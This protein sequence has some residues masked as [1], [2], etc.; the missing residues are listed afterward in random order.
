[1][2]YKR[3]TKNQWQQFFKVLN[4]GEKV[5]FLIFSVFFFVSFTVLAVDFYYNNTK[6]VP[7]SGGTYIEGIVGSP[8]FINP[9]YA[10]SSDVDRDIIQLIFSG[11]MKYD[12]EGN[13]Q[14][15][16]A[17]DYNVFEDGKIYEFYL[18]ED[19]VWQDL[20]P[21][22]ADDIIFTIETIQS[23]E[24]KSSLRSAWLGVEV[25][26]MSDYS[27][28]FK[29]ANESS[30]FLENCTL[31][32]IPKHIW[33]DVSPNNFSLTPLNLNPVGSGPYKLENLAQNENGEIVS[34][35]LIRN[36][37]HFGKAP[38]L[39]KIFFEFFESEDQL[40]EAYQRGGI[41][42]FSS[43]SIENL[44]EKGNTYFFS[45]PRYFTIFLNPENSKA[46]EEKDVRI[47]LNRGTDKNEILNT[48]FSGKGKIVDSPILP[49]IYGFEQPSKTYEYNPA[50]AKNILE[51]AG[52]L[53]ME[54]GFREKVVEKKP[55][56]TFK[57]YLSLGSRSSDVSE[58]QK[59]LSK[60]SDVY[61]EAKIT[62]YFGTITKQAVVRFQEKYKKDILDPIGLKKGTGTVGG[63]TREKLN[64]V[65]FEEPDECISLKFSLTTVNQPSLIQIAETLKEQWKQ[66]G[67]DL[68]VESLD[69]S[70][71]ERET[72]RKRKF[73]ALL[74]GEVLGMIPDPFPFWHSS[75]KGELG[76]NLINYENKEVDKLLEDNRKSLDKAERQGKLEEFQNLLIEDCPVVFLYNPDYIYFASEEIDG[77]DANT[78]TDPSKRF[79]GIGEWYIKTKRVWK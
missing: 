43:S 31:K 45:I 69:I 65:C 32:I 53:I 51:E 70:T 17:K 64:E 10:T 52:F 8:R 57:N 23:A 30:V 16:I 13:I 39:S 79:A 6:I 49:N 78:I 22:T 42:G 76:L 25:E 20:K 46:F 50:K 33:E 15:D 26:K 74:F 21:L 54:N 24:I 40:A 19:V 61:P 77:I 60:D 37:S 38:Y 71:I 75:Q 1:M 27:L 36:E 59:C 29:L 66:L 41:K 72:L 11:L 12:S 3:P 56:F 73:E 63:K 5:L 7:A 55:S 4:K 2:S 9:I 47:A 44:P 14:L 58:L 68:E 18:K 28:R 62:G 35:G 34:L 48:F 67:I